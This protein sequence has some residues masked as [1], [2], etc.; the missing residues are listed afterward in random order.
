MAGSVKHGCTTSSGKVWPES[1]WKYVYPSPATGQM[2]M[3]Y[4]LQRKDGEESCPPPYAYRYVGLE[5]SSTTS[6]WCTMNIGIFTLPSLLGTNT[7]ASCCPLNNRAS[8]HN[9][10]FGRGPYSVEAATAVSQAC[11][12]II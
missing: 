9:Q 10:C 1:K 6:L 3:I 2:P 12:A 5:P 8:P 4:K 7:C 11:L